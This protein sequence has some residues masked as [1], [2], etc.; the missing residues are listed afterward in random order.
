MRPVTIR[1]AVVATAGTK[2]GAIFLA[3]L[4]QKTCDDIR[5]AFK[6]A[7]YPAFASSASVTSD[8]YIIADFVDQHGRGHSGAFAGLYDDFQS[9]VD[10]LAK[11]LRLAGEE[12]KAY[13][14]QMNAWVKEDWRNVR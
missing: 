9:N 7:D 8:G 4:D 12:L 5:A 2:F 10:G 3:T 11:H 6:L 14:N 1:R 13:R